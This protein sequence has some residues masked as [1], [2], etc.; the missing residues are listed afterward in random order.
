MEQRLQEEVLLQLTHQGSIRNIIWSDHLLQQ[1]IQ[2][3]NQ[4]WIYTEQIRHVHF[5]QDGE[6]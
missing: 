4:S 5:Q 3:S 6:Q 1:S 2:T